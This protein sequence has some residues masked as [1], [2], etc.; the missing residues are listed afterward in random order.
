[1]YIQKDTL[2]W[3]FRSRMTGANYV[4]CANLW[5]R[6][7]PRGNPPAIDLEWRTKP[8]F[9]RAWLLT[10]DSAAPVLAPILT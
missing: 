6:R 8:I 1:M 10:G 7:Q 3:D 5:R 9:A 2:G 4:T